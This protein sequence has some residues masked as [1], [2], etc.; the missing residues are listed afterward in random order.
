MQ[1]ESTSSQSIFWRTQPDIQPDI[2]PNEESDDLG[3][4]EEIAKGLK[5]IRNLDILLARK[6]NVSNK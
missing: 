4:P 1:L 3:V 2:L 5:D 6:T